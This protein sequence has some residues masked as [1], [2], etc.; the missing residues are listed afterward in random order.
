MKETKSGSAISRGKVDKS[1]CSHRYERR[2]E[3]Q[4]GRKESVG[5]VR[6]E[7]RDTLTLHLSE[8]IAGNRCFDSC[9]EY[10][11]VATET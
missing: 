9:A 7:E 8:A 6:S 3:S 1:T 10:K 2:C 4:R 5:D 11:Q